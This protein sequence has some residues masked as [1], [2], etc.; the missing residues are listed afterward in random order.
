VSRW[1]RFLG[2]RLWLWCVMFEV[3]VG[4]WLRQFVDS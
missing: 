1:S 4:G 3:L 2:F